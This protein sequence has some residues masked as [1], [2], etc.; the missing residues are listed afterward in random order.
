MKKPPTPSPPVAASQDRV[1]PAWCT[2]TITDAVVYPGVSITSPQNWNN[3]QPGDPAPS[4]TN[5]SRNYLVYRV[6]GIDCRNGTLTGSVTH[7]LQAKNNGG[8]S[9]NYMPSVV[10][11]L[12]NRGYA[13]GKVTET[14]RAQSHQAIPILCASRQTSTTEASQGTSAAR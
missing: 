2:R 6:S 3:P 10:I 8:F 7:T 4:L 14:L 13:T 11:A 12:T 5:D 9:L 1:T